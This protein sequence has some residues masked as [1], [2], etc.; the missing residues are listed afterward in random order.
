M[1]NLRF[2]STLFIIYE[3]FFYLVIGQTTDCEK[4]YYYLYG[5]AG[6]YLYTCCDELNLQIECFPQGSI[7]YFTNTNATDFT[8]FPYL[9]EIEELHIV[10]YNKKYP[11]STIPDSI[12]K[13]TSLKKLEIVKNNIEVIPPEIQ[14]LSLLEGLY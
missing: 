2:L 14:K 6:Q 1:K 10:S 12:L 4:L 13:L 9:P 5:K 8:N 3:T 7:K 11:L